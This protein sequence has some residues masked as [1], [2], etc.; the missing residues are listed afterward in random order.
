MQAALPSSALLWGYQITHD[1]HHHEL[2]AAQLHEA[3]KR[4]AVAGNMLWLHVQSD[5][6]DATSLLQSMGVESR[7]ID[8]LL[9]LETRPR[10][11]A[12]CEG[13]LVYL[14]GINK[15]PNADPEDMVSLRIWFNNSL[16]ITARRKNRRLASIMQVKE[17]IEANT[18][19]S[20][21]ANLVI[22]MVSSVANTIVDVVDDMDDTLVNFEA[23]EQLNK[24]DRQTLA[25][26]R[27]QAAAMRRYLA[28]QRDALDALLRLPNVL[29]TQQSFELREQ[30]DR[31]A[32]Y[33]EDMDLQRERAIVLQDELRN[34]IAEQQGMRMYVLSL[35]TAIF[36]P[37]SF[38]TGVFGMNVGGLPGID[39]V[40]GFTYVV[41]AMIFLAVC[42]LVAMLWKRWL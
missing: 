21:P 27:R 28:P 7:V 29:S 19:I 30:I 26:V 34:R 40:N 14:R 38:L 16:I 17:Q 2:D 5:A 11:M 37:L 22:N 1:N 9:A 10:A 18:P 8:S 3:I 12:L 13:T 32:R 4:P 42:M 33:V 31:M 15:N 20:H 24:Q 25:A 6:E 39:S 35:V 41:G 36:L 23:N